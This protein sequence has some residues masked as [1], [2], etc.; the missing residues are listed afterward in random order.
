MDEKGNKSGENNGNNQNNED[1][2][3]NENSKLEIERKHQNTSNLQTMITS[4]KRP[5]TFCLGSYPFYV[6][7]IVN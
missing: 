2:Q 5:Q 4:T 7:R 3:N 6:F 1:N